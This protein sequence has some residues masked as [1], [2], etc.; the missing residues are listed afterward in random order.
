VIPA[1]NKRAPSPLCAT[2]V[3]KGL[4]LN[5]HEGRDLEATSRFSRSSR[6]FVESHGTGFSLLQ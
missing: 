2:T 6:G 3:F 4:R 5:G 1:M